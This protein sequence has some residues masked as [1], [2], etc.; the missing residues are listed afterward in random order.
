MADLRVLAWFARRS[1]SYL[2]CDRGTG[3]WAA[4]GRYLRGL[5]A[6]ARTF[7][8]ATREDRR[9]GYGRV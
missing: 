2:G 4:R 3:R 1:W 8:R 9:A 7:L 5:P 6:A